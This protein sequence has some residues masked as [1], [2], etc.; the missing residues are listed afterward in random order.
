MLSPYGSTMSYWTPATGSCTVPQPLIAEAVCSYVHGHVII[1]LV[2]C[3]MIQVLRTANQAWT[4]LRK[5][6][7]SVQQIM[8]VNQ[9]EL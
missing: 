1:F 2:L 4:A 6:I 5:Y 7:I 3:Y 8:T 9:L